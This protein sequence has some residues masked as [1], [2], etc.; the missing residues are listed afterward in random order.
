MIML[1]GQYT[2]DDVVIGDDIYATNLPLHLIGISFNIAAVPQT[3]RRHEHTEV[4]GE[5]QG[6][7]DANR[8]LFTPRFGVGGGLVGG[9]GGAVG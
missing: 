1:E 2:M 5:L 4:L 6:M 8:A 9:A 7:V 3:E